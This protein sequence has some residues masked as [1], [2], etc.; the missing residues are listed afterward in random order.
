MKN[1]LWGTLVVMLAA[2]TVDKK[3]DYT[4]MSDVE[5]FNAGMEN[6][7]DDY[8]LTAVQDFAQLEQNHPYSSL[9]DNSW[10]MM[11]YTY[12][13]DGKYPEAID[14]FENIIKYQPNNFQVPYAMYMVAISYYD[15]IS[16]ISRDQKMTELSLGKMEQLVKKFPESKYAEDVKPKIIIARNNLAAKEMYIAKHLVK[17]KN[18]IAALNR[19]QTVII[20]YDTSIFIEE[21]LYRTVEIYLLLDEKQDATNI[22][23]VLELNYPKSSWTTDAK[24][25]IDKYPNP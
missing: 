8:T 20:R 10:V 14:A 7:K 21:A 4:K 23:T 2:C 24:N 3:I 25:L 5:I 22:F 9:V 12:Y 19:F 15:Q 18:L 17:R 1:I 13:I 6:L 16:P 11:G